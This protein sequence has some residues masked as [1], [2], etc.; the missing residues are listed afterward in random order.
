MKEAKIEILL[1]MVTESDS[2]IK[3]FNCIISCEYP[4]LI[5]RV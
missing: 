5:G 3:M 2:L 4:F 1:N